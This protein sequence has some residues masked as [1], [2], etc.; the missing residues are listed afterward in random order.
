VTNPSLTITSAISNV[1]LNVVQAP[2][3]T[4]SGVVTFNGAQPTSSCSSS[5]R[6]TIT[7][8][9]AS[10]SNYNTSMVVPCNGATTPFAFT[11]QLYPSTYSV[12]VRGGLSNLPGW[13]IVTNPSLTITSAIS[14]LTL[15]VVQAPAVT[16][17]GTVTHN[18]AQPTSNC[19]SSDR[20][21][22]TF[23]SAANSNYNTSVVVPCNGATT[24]FAWTAQLYPS[25][26]SVSVRGGLSSLPGWSIVTN[27]SLTITSAISNVT[28]N[29][30]QA[31]TVAVSGTVTLNGLQPTSNCSSSDR[32][33]VTFTSAAN[34]NYNTSVVVPC[35][36]ATTPFAW[37]AQ[38]YPSTY[39]VSVRGGLSSLPGWSIVTNASLT[40]T[41]AISNVTLNVVQAP[42]VTVSGVVTLNG[43][44][45]TSSCSSSDRA[46]ITF[47]SAANSNYN[48]S[49]VVPCN[50]ATTA[51]AWTAQLYP[52]TYR[53]AV[54]G[55]LSN[56]PG[57]SVVVVDA[58]EVR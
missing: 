5:D 46:T 27:P 7:F 12:S 19:S 25:T 33:T 16:V 51:F 2:A 29:V 24:P 49:V 56:L 20:A 6:A 13:A 57:W 10:N 14:N 18:G 8:T 4:V 15:N 42:T 32:A 43:M 39:S 53:V 31:P 48:T 1:T 54:R 58:L 3:V 38:L 35:N 22:V 40:I 36:G 50:G 28:L 55:G 9:S 44:Q 26:Y 41:G 30:V 17:S 23:T 37:T 45:P 11:G 47:T 52:S 21:T 34:S